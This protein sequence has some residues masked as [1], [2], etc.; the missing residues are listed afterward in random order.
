[1]SPLL[2]GHEPITDVLGARTIAPRNS[3]SFTSVV[4]LAARSSS[5]ITVSL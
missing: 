2:T 4:A 5:W 1:M 3:I